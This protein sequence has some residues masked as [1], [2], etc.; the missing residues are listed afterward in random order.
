MFARY[1]LL[2]NSL[3]LGIAGTLEDDMCVRQVCEVVTTRAAVLVA[4]S[5]VAVATK[6]WNNHGKQPMEIGCGV[7]GSL[8]LKH[9]TGS[10]SKFRW[11]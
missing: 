4:C 3:R 7:D 5:V 11:F 8:F 9:S 1:I 10:P 2:E 6:V